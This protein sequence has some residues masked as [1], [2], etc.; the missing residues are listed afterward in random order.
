MHISVK[1]EHTCVIVSS[2]FLLE[3]FVLSLIVE[4]LRKLS[5]ATKN[6]I[7]GPNKKISVFRVTRPYLKVLVKAFL[8]DFLKKYNSMHFER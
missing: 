7:I 5:V 4:A 3:L 2:D 6:K 1:T 8:S